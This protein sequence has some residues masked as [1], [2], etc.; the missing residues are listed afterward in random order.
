MLIRI[1]TRC[2]K[3]RDLIHSIPAG[4]SPK[5]HVDAS[6]KEGRKKSAHHPRRY[7]TS[8]A[9]ATASAKLDTETTRHDGPI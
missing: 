7:G 4:Q 2:I 3:I 5:G 1:E 6:R 8:F 9:S